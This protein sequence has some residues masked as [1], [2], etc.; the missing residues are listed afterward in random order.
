[1]C[2]SEH[3]R[4]VLMNAT[5]VCAI[6]SMVRWLPWPIRQTCNIGANRPLNEDQAP[7][8]VEF[9]QLIGI[10][11]EQTARTQELERGRA[12]GEDGHVED[13]VL[14]AKVVDGEVQ[15]MVE[16]GSSR[17]SPSSLDNEIIR[18]RPRSK[19][20]PSMC[21]SCTRP[22]SSMEA[23]SVVTQQSSRSRH[24]CGTLGWRGKFSKRAPAPAGVDWAQTLR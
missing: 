7:T 19:R 4:G 13:D 6:Q 1:M 18:R 5:G 24:R 22:A 15:D 11:I 12:F 14:H 10:Q 23:G 20:M 8:R 9:L 21:R 16:A 3:W 17:C 2:R